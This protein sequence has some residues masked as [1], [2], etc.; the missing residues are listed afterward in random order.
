MLPSP[1]SLENMKPDSVLFSRFILWQEGEFVETL[2]SF[3]CALVVLAL[4]SDR[5]ALLSWGNLWVPASLF[6]VFNQP[7]RAGY[8]Y[9][10]SF[11]ELT[12][13]K[14]SNLR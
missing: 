12:L 7:I 9:S 14:Y 2:A 11:F 6:S 3:A 1:I 13:K 4:S 5:T 10:Q 8:A